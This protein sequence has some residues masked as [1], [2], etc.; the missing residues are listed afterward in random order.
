[1][2]KPF[3]WEA[4]AAL[5]T[6]ASRGIGAEIARQLAQRGTKTLILVAR[7]E[8]DLQK[9][10]SEIR[11]TYPETR[12]EI[13]PADLAQPDA[14]RALKAE[15]DR[16]GLPVHLLVNNAGFGSHGNFETRDASGEQDMVAV[17]VSALVTLTRL[18][19]PEMVARK[20][21]GVLNIGST[22]GFQPVPYMT[23]YGATK[24][25]VQSFSEA[26]WAEMQDRATDVRVVCLCPGATATNFADKLD[27]GKFENSKKD[28][29]EEVARV[30]LDA[31]DKTGPFAV[32]GGA[33]YVV[34]LGYRIMPRAMMARF[35][36]GMFRP[37]DADT[38]TSTAGRAG[39]KAGLVIAAAGATALILA[40]LRS[41][42]NR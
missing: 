4:G 37:T 25:F 6:G 5:V 10:A 14:P 15:T 7:S 1:M 42:P 26:L 19:L 33:N 13:V 39:K 35:V 22:A 18:Y 36:A 21:G 31:L 38:E 2:T 41:K 8:A 16:R 32:V 34:S 17:N 28:S 24:A 11:T 12:I 27:R 29:A 23:T 40:A 3:E 9:L 30:G 20:T